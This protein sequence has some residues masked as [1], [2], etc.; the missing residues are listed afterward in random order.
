MQNYTAQIQYDRRNVMRMAHVVCYA[1]EKVTPPLL[2]LSG[3]AIMAAGFYRMYVAGD[4]LPLLL[5]G[6][7]I[8]TNAD[9]RGRAMGRKMCK[10]ME[11]WWPLMKFSFEEEGIHSET[12]REKMVTP[13]RDVIRL[14]DE[15]AFYYV[16]TGPNTA[17]MID[18]STLS[19]K[20]QDGFMAMLMRRTG[21]DWTAAGGFPWTFKA[22]QL[23]KKNRA[24]KAHGDKA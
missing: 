24:L 10:F 16:F 4:G 8:V 13:Y 6:I 12:Y 19:P 23:K 17:F 20:D 5:I 22:L 1:Y 11:G 2:Q 9:V 18:K 7:L 3:M 15:R 14:I 21:Q